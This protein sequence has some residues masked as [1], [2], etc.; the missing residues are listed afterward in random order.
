MDE[1]RIFLANLCRRLLEGTE[2]VRSRLLVSAPAG[3][4][5]PCLREDPL[6]RYENHVINITSTV[7]GAV[8]TSAFSLEAAHRVRF[9]TFRR[10]NVGVHEMADDA[11]GVVYKVE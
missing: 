8:I 3:V 5:D 9:A 1:H 10:S 11:S 4:N 2:E 7:L 6:Q